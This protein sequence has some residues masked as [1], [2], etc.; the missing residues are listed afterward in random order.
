V[1]LDDRFVQLSV[2][3]ESHTKVVADCERVRIELRGLLVLGNGL[4]QLPLFKEGIPEVGV[5]YERVGIDFQGLLVLGNSLIQ[6]PFLK[7]SQTKVAAGFHIVRVNFQ[8]FFWKC[9]NASSRC[10]FLKKASPRLLWPSQLFGFLASVSVQSVS[11]L[12]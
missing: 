1:E 12:A 8:S 10:S 9:I 6:L 7:Q 4:V 5:G 11:S 2:L 3:K